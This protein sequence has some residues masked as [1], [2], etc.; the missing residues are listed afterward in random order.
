MIL[1]LG[2]KLK[3]QILLILNT[4]I[5]RP[6]PNFEKKMTKNKVKCFTKYQLGDMRW[7]SI[8]TTY[9]F[10]D[11]RSVHLLYVATSLVL[12]GYTL[13]MYLPMYS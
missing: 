13:G 2:T 3:K 4:K 5:S 7:I 10:T 1:Y 6:G 11:I 12:F 9:E 8:Y